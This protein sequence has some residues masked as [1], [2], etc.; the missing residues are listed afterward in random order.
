M[1]PEGARHHTGAPFFVSSGARGGF[2][3]AW[4]ADRSGRKRATH[5]S[6][7]G[8]NPA[9]EAGAMEGP[10]HSRMNCA[11]WG[12]PQRTARGAR[13]RRA[14]PPFGTIELDLIGHYLMESFPPKG[15]GELPSLP[16]LFLNSLMV[17]L[18]GRLPYF[19]SN[20]ETVH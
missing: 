18:Q 6:A 16:G 12:T 5:G 8:P 15:C 9:A 10:P 11:P 17:S 1:K 19:L 13:L 20:R 7:S 14:N 4:G 2:E 3:R